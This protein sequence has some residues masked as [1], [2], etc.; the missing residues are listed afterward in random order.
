MKIFLQASEVGIAVSCSVID[1]E[2][3]DHQP[4]KLLTFKKILLPRVFGEN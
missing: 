4:G 2:A 1:Y 3:G